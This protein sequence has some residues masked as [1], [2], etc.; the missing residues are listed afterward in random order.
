MNAFQELAD[1]LHSCIQQNYLCGV[2][3][4]SAV[5]TPD[6]ARDSLCR[7]FAIVVS[8]YKP[9][10]LEKQ[11][12]KVTTCGL[13]SPPFVSP[14]KSDPVLKLVHWVVVI[15]LSVFSSPDARCST[16]CVPG[17]CYALHIL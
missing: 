2:E 4:S 3:M 15:V 17:R 16:I 13:C 7:S 1:V 5:I 11:K 9:I 14:I 12:K 8:S 6:T 10:V